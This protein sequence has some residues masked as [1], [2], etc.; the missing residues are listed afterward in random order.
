MVA[1]VRVSKITLFSLPHPLTLTCPLF[2]EHPRWAL[3]VLVD[4]IRRMQSR[5]ICID[6]DENASF[7]ARYMTTVTITVAVTEREKLCPLSSPYKHHF[8]AQDLLFWGEVSSLCLFFVRVSYRW[9]FFFVF[10][11]LCFVLVH[12]IVTI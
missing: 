2:F 4:R 5:H 12:V 1:M 7:V 11:F 3:V 9:F 6:M 8:A 10:C